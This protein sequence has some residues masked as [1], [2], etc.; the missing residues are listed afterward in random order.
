MV[1][2][3]P[4][5]RGRATGSRIFVTGASLTVPSVTVVTRKGYGLGAQ[6][7]VG[8]RLL[9]VGETLAWP[10]A[11]FGAGPAGRCAGMRRELEAIEDEDVAR[12]LYQ[13]GRR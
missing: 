6:A 2:P 13:N 10:T 8:G 1:G 5:H 9:R 11:E 12:A 7:M 3:Q 4:R